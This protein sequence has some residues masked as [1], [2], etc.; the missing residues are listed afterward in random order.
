MDYSHEEVLIYLS[1][2]YIPQQYEKTTYN[3]EPSTSKG[4]QFPQI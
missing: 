4:I 3:L 2:T 1:A